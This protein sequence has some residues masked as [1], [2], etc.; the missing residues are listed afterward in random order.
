MFAG[1][2]WALGSNSFDKNYSWLFLQYYGGKTKSGDYFG[3]DAKAKFVG[4]SGWPEKSLRNPEIKALWNKWFDLEEYARQWK[5]ARFIGDV[6]RAMTT[7]WYLEWVDRT[8][9]PNVQ[10]CLAGKISAD[11]AA[12]NIAKGAAELKKRNP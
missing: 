6:C 12:D 4:T 2:F 5:D 1:H 8:L 7:T 9:V 11:V 3:A 10:N